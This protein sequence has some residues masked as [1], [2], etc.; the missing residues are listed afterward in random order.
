MRK[1]LFFGFDFEDTAQFQKAINIFA[2]TMVLMQIASALPSLYFIYNKKYKPGFMLF[3][4]AI[5]F[6]EPNSYLLRKNHEV[7]KRLDTL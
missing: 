3:A 5:A 4:L 6:G 2:E 7:N 1:E